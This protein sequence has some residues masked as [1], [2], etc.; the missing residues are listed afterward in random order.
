MG[1]VSE[2]A[3]Q[4]SGTVGADRD[5]LR[6]ELMGF[7]R[8]FLD[9]LESQGEAISLLRTGGWRP[10]PHFPETFAPVEARL[11]AFNFQEWDEYG[12]IEAL[13]T[14]RPRLRRL[15]TERMNA[16]TT[17]A[18]EFMGLLSGVVAIPIERYHAIHGSDEEGLAELIDELADWFCRDADPMFVAV[19]IIGFTAPGPLTLAPGITVRRASDE[20]VGAMLEIGAL[21]PG[22]RQNPTDIWT[23]N[24]PDAARWVVAM[25]HARPRRFGGTPQ[26]EDEPNLSRLE[27]TAGA[28]LAVLRILTPA[29]VRLGPILTTNLVGGIMSG[30]S[31]NGDAPRALFA[32]HNPAKITPDNVATFRG[33]AQGIVGGRAKRLGVAHGLHRFSD[34][35]TRASE[36]DRLVDLVIS[37]ESMFS[38]G[39][40]SVSYKVSR[41]ASA[42]FGPLGLSAGTIHQFVKDAYSSRS[43][44]VH[45]RKPTYRNLACEKCSADEQV[46]ELDRLVA[47]AFRQILSSASSERPY[48]TADELIDAALDSHDRPPT[49]DGSALYEVTVRHDGSSFTAVLPADS[50]F[51]VRGDTVESLHGQLADTVALWTQ[52]PCEPDQIRL[53]LD[54]DATA[55]SS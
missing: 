17:A 4:L 20:E 13:V 41:R 35:T 2:D 3:A 31:L 14:S 15:V 42:M 12:T 39:G 7:G 21:N 52:A 44:V 38:E 32:W 34:V 18:A 37:L 55:A 1:R 40:D 43:D 6:P 54:D 11:P 28:W 25:D 16:Q 53:E 8:R 10:H 26:K 19:P 48:V 9:A 23:L 24:V 30:G 50:T 33:L 5:A 36:A 22:G 51:L 27:E 29:Q 49:S 46:R 45:G 47:G